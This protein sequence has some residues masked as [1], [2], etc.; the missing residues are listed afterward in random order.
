MKLGIIGLPQV[1]KKTIFSLLTGTGVTKSADAQKPAEGVADIMDPRFDALAALY[2]PKKTVRARL[3]LELLPD[4][5]ADAIREGKIFRNI[6]DTDALCHIVRA[7]SDDSVYHVSGSVDPGRDIASINSELVL[8]DLVF[9]EKRLERIE[10]EKAR[11]KDDRMKK[12]EEL[13]LRFKAHLEGEMPLRTLEISPEEQK[14]ISG[15]PFITTKAMLVALNLSDGEIGSDA[16]LREF[17]AKYAAERITFMRISAKLESEIAL[18]DSDAERREFM[19][20]AGIEEP[21]VNLLSRLCMKALGLISF[22]T[23]GKDEV[24]Q[25][26]IRDHTLAPEAGGAIHS[27]IQRGFIRA[28]VMKYPDLIDLKS[29]DEVKKAGKFMLMGK[30]Y[31]VEDGDIICFRF[32]V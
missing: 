5:S 14:L 3:N 6:A 18:L 16:M 27:D 19:E 26:L 12:E 29:E 32:N 1:G 22:F 28:E 8:H 17:E 11:Q 2:E 13:M 7:F 10:K 15:Y 23:V 4:L 25:W 9:I 24:R 21:A 20:A 30:D 31:R